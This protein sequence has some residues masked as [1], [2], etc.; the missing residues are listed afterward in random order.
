MTPEAIDW[1]AFPT[2]WTM[3]FSRIDAL[4][5]ARRI[6]ID[7]TEIGIDAATVSPARSPTYTV[8]IPKTMANSAPSSSAR[9]VSSGR[10]SDAGTNG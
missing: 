5:N 10:V 8:T 3:L 2:V 9:K 1:P 4:P 6:V 7:R